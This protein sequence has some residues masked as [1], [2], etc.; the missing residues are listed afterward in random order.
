MSSPS[1][2]AKMDIQM[3]TQVDMHGNPDGY[4]ANAGRGP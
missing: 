2:N 3:H 1:D 4:L